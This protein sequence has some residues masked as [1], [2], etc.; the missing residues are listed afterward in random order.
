MKNHLSFLCLFLFAFVSK[1]EDMRIQPIQYTVHSDKKEATIKDGYFKISGTVKMFSSLSPIDNVLVGCTSSGLWVRTNENG[2]FELLLKATDSVIYFYKEE[3][4]EVV[5]Q[6]YL[7]KNQHHVIMEVWLAHVAPQIMKKPVI[8]L[9][10]DKHTSASVS[11]VPKGEM[12]F[13][14][15]EYKDNWIVDVS[16]EN[17]IEL[18]GRQYPYLFWEAETKQLK[19]TIEKDKVEGF[20]V[21]KDQLISFF[22]KHLA[23]LGLNQTEQTD[24]ITFWG[25]ALST[26]RFA[27]I[28]FV[29]DDNY[30]QEICELDVVPKPDSQRRIFI[31]CSPL[32]DDNLGLE[33]VP[34]TF[35]P[36]ERKGF[37][38]IEWG[39]GII[40]RN[41]ILP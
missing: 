8:Y 38:L 1:A 41:K 26:K 20:L 24:F 32:E 18:N 13:T 9:Y 5:V 6:D 36:F 4:S 28:Q 34:Q 21:S 10:A 31:K 16:P 23:I 15:P 27:F 3:W 37:T 11:I 2:E 12:S 22:E 25:P 33:I 39:G 7:F 30:N 29:V 40:D 19:Y 14:Y 35:A 17:G